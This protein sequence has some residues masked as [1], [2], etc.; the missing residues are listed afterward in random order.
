MNHGFKVEPVDEGNDVV[1]LEIR[2]ELKMAGASWLRKTCQWR[3]QSRWA[4]KH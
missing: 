2:K 3:S 4:E 1:R